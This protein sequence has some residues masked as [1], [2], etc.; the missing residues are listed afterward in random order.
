MAWYKTLQ[1][2]MSGNGYEEDGI[3]YPRVT[4][5]V[6]IKAKPALYSFY[7]SM[8]SFAAGEAM[9]E[10]SAEEGTLLHET[11]EA[12]FKKELVTVP[13]SIKPAMD[14]FMEFYSNNQI[15]V[16]K[17]EE[18]LVSHKHRYAGTM[19]VLADLNGQL[20]V[21]DIK[22]SIAIYRDYQIQTSAYVEA[23]KE[24][25]NMP[26]LTR[27]ILRVDQ[28]KKCLHCGASLRE[29]GGRQKIRKENG[30]C[31]HEWGPMTGEYEIKEL[32]TFTSDIKA[33]LAAKTLWEWENE[34]WLTRLGY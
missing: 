15:V 4:S 2:F 24:N 32:K 28:S 17:V 12:I 22:T 1:E 26:E 8:P 27:W 30:P 34:Y 19:D 11:V 10:K 20:G 16:H 3:W 7:A 5:I 23:L 18:R 29:K 9:K 6:G 33:F 14:A 31:E 13:D 25:P 21:L